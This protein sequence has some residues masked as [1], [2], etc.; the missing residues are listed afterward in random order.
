MQVEANEP[1]RSFFGRLR[2]S[3]EGTQKVLTMIPHKLVFLGL[4][5]LSFPIVSS[6]HHSRAAQYDLSK[7][8]EVEG[9]V[10]E[11]L[12]QNPHIA[13]KLR[14]RNENGT[15][16][17]WQLASVSV[18]AL[19]A[20]K[21]E[22]GFVEVGD[23]IRVAGNPERSRNGAYISNVLTADGR[24][25][26]IGG[27]K[28]RWQDAASTVRSAR[29]T[30]PGDTSAPQL[31]IF[32]VWST[33]PGTPGLMENNMGKDAAVRVKLTPAAIQAVDGFVFERD[34]PLKNCA[35][36]GMPAIMHAPYPT[37]FVRA[38]AN[39]EF[40]AEEFDTVRTIHMEPNV[41]ADGQPAS[42]LGYSVGRWENERT[43]VVTTSKMNWGYV[44]SDG[45]PM[46][47]QAVA[48][49]RFVVSPQGDR[50]DYTLSVS[51]PVNLKEPLSFA[52]HWVWYPDVH[53]ERYDCTPAPGADAGSND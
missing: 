33:A 39:I 9:E 8:V 23:V 47:T 10:T 35:R 27:S 13:I 36:K 48:V 32:R 29:R 18:T 53:V 26:I 1:L 37:E 43:L 5:L 21:I 20:A 25:V 28:A 7:E 16:E 38:G 50:L 11:V 24:E 31:G 52:K 42:L 19:R 17:E 2:K 6:A 46:S 45:L 51:D 30:G 41:S 44:D 40:H 3:T 4:G 34:N 14:V 22:P 49:E 15:T 12:W